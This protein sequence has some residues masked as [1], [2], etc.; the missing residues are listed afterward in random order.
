MPVLLNGRDMPGCLLSGRTGRKQA[1]PGHHET[2]AV[3]S[4]TD[5]SDL[6]DFSGSGQTPRTTYLSVAS[7][8]AST[9]TSSMKS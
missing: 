6:G 7:R 8:L 9:R 1:A 2:D 5:I 3:E 4:R